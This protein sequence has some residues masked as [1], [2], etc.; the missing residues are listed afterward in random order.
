MI[1][2][3][4]WYAVDVNAVRAPII[5]G[6]GKKSFV[7]GADIGEMRALTPEEGEAGKKGNDV[8]RKIENIPYSSNCCS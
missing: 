8:F 3:Q 2:M 1:W 6:A 5:T 4:L 7:A